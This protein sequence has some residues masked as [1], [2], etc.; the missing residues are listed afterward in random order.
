MKVYSTVLYCCAVIG[1]TAECIGVNTFALAIDVRCRK[2]ETFYPPNNK[3]GL[4]L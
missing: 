1:R 2:I 3:W 4:V